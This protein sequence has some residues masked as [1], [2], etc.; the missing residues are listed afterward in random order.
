MMTLDDASGE[1]ASGDG[2]DTSDG[3]G[4]GIG[5]LP[6]APTNEP[7]GLMSG[8]LV[9]SSSDSEIE[10]GEEA[11]AVGEERP[12]SAIPR[13][14]CERGKA[15]PLLPVDE[16]VVVDAVLALRGRMLLEFPPARCWLTSWSIRDTPGDGLRL[17]GLLPRL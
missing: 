4:D 13:D 15:L 12:E 6:D 16:E 2:E 8:G 11:A 3:G 10:S 7:S 14:D 17:C 5:E 9:G 1:P